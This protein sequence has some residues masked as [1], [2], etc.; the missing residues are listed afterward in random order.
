[1][2]SSCN[3]L[4]ISTTLPLSGRQKRKQMDDRVLQLE[5]AAREAEEHARSVDDARASQ[6]RHSWDRPGPSFP[7]LALVR[8]K[9]R[10][11]GCHLKE[12]SVRSK[13]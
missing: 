12:G 3:Q 13:R 11:V 10:T 1:M 9:R 7:L 2:A 6:V 4:V 5:Q 8:A